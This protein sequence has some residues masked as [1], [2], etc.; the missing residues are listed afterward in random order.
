MNL[1]KDELATGLKARKYNLGFLERSL[2]RILYGKILGIIK[3]FTTEA[4]VPALKLSFL[5][6]E[7]LQGRQNQDN[8]DGFLEG[9]CT[10]EF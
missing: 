8:A 7:I 10:L 1:T 9:Q 5:V 6:T 4:D 2:T 3:S